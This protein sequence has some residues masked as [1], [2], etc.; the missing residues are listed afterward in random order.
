MTAAAIKAAAARISAVFQAAGAAPVEAAILQPAD[1]L[2]DLYGEDIR[3]RAYVTND[4]MHGEMMLRPDFTVPVVQM[5]MQSHADPARYTYAGT[6]FRKQDEDP[7]RAREYTQVGYEVFDGQ[8]P[9]AADADVFAT[10]QAALGGVS[11][12]A[13]TGDIG[14]LKAAIAGLRTTDAR[15]AALMRHIWRPKRFK[16]MLDRFG[17]R[18]TPPAKRVA[19]LAATDP[20]AQAGPDVGLRARSEVQTRIAALQAD[21]QAPAISGDEIALIEALLSLSETATNVL[22]AL[23]DIAVDMPAID[24]AVSTLHARLDALAARGVDVEALP[25]EGS[26]GRTS[27]E[28]YD[29]FVFG[30]YGVKDSRPVANGGRYDALTEVLGDGRAVPAVGAVIRPDLLLELHAC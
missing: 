26:Y 6:V 18:T 7:S 14:L 11:V 29:G 3:G 25:F 20:F 24:H 12:R 4:P 27:L 9:A 15:K 2:L 21:A 10:V 8:N 1:V 16:A 30:F 17:G 22:S 5:H 28:Y 13:A 23:R 19:L